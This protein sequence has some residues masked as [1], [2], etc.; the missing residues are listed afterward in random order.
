MTTPAP[1]VVLLPGIGGDGAR[2]FVFLEPMLARH[3][4]VVSISYPHETTLAAMVGRARDAIAATYPGEAVQLV[5]NGLGAAVA[6]ALANTV[7]VDAV[8]LIAGSI[9]P[10]ARALLFAATWEQLARETDQSEINRT[11]TDQT[12]AD[13][14]DTFARFAAFS[15][16]F[17]DTDTADTLPWDGGSAGAQT[18]AHVALVASVTLTREAELVRAP[19]LVI[20]ATSD[21]IA[22]LEQSRALFG[23][24]DDARLVSLAA[25]YAV[26]V[27]RPAEVLSF[28]DPFLGAPTA[29]P[30]GSILPTERV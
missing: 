24:I 1:P 3:R 30:A 5:G 29:H 15:G 25:G 23:A 18:N 27:E 28:V 17:L 16:P 8:V 14:R 12:A 20:A 10:S 26:L 11:A 6:I 19:T 22:G 21:A 2:D 9:T 4:R 13:S 7:A